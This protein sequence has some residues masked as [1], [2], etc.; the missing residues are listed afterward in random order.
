MRDVLIGTMPPASFTDWRYLAVPVVAGLVA[1]RFHPGLGEIERYINWFDAPG[2]RPVLRHRLRRRRCSSVSTRV[3]AALMGVL[4]GIGG[5]V[6]R[7]LLGRSDARSCCG[8]TSTRSRRWPDRWSSWS[9]GRRGKFHEW[10]LIPA[11]ALC[12]VL[13]FL[14]LHYRWSAPRATDLR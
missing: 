5:G 1:F 7:D 11:A 14:A 8:R 4:T 10:V 13:R 2:P 6:L 9:P 3:P 12:I